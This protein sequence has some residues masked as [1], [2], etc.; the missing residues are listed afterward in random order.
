M[1][2]G[3]PSK[4]I[5]ASLNLTSSYF[6]FS[7]NDSN[8]NNYSPI[9]SSSFKLKKKS[10]VYDNLRN[11]QDIVYFQDIKQNQKLSFLLMNDMK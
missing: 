2:I 8:I 3:I 7:S 10:K 9:K 1:N 6:Y 11:A 5:N 4:K